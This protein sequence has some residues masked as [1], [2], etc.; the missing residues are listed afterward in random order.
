ML[1]AGDRHG[2]KLGLGGVDRDELDD[3]FDHRLVA[4]GVALRGWL[5][6]RREDGADLV[7]RLAVEGVEA[8]G[9]GVG[10]GLGHGGSD[11]GWSDSLTCD[12]LHDCQGPMG[13]L[14]G[15]TTPIAGAAGRLSSGLA[16]GP[17]LLRREASTNPARR[18][19]ERRMLHRP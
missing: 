18:R 11:G 4:F 2:G 3:G 14:D 12:R 8:L 13:A 16:F 17:F 1:V 9:D 6:G 10:E 19:N 7:E 15:G 5:E